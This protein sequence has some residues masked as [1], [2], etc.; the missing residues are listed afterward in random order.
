MTEQ[1]RTVVGFPYYEVSNMGRVRSVDRVL[2]CKDGGSQKFRGRVLKGTLNKGRPTVTLA[3]VGRNSSRLVSHLVAEA[4]IG[5]RPEGMPH[6]CHNDGNPTNNC[7]ANLRY[8][9]V[10]GNQMDA[11][12]HGTHRNAHTKVCRRGHDLVVPNLVPNLLRL[13]ARSCYAC[14]RAH[15]YLRRHPEG[16]FG[17]VAGRYYDNLMT[18]AQL[19]LRYL[20]DPT[21]CGRQVHLMT[22]SNV[23]TVPNKGTRR[24]K[25]CTTERERARR[26]RKRGVDT[27]VEA[28]PEVAA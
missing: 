9:T 13:G 25:A 23:Y 5:E 8:D 1:W 19:P 21:M 17:A 12:R 7:S 6:L 2:V 18:G 28:R 22:G 15:D 4:W 26:L 3:V 20:Q 11:V 16:D 10:S 14:Q 27:S 24:C